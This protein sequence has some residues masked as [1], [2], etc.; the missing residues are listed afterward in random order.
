MRK[1]QCSD[2]GSNWKATY[3]PRRARAT[4]SGGG[5]PIARTRSEKAWAT[6][7]SQLW[8]MSSMGQGGPAQEAQ[9]GPCSGVVIEDDE[10]VEVATS[11]GGDEPG[12]G[13]RRAA[14]P[15]PTLLVAGGSARP[16]PREQ[17]VFVGVALGEEEEEDLLGGVD[18]KGVEVEGPEASGGGGRP[19]GGR[20]AAG[21]VPHVLGAAGGTE[22]LGAECSTAALWSPRD[23]SARRRMQRA[24]RWWRVLRHPPVVPVQPG[25]AGAPR[26]RAGASEPGLTM[27]GRAGRRG[28]RTAPRRPGGSAVPPPP[29]GGRRGA[30]P[31]RTK[32]GFE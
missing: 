13:S 27:E 5:A 20:T 16:E 17:V 10:D 9:E 18:G 3:R 22:E 7:M 19:G 29:S 30:M 4:G 1:A 15:A 25:E 28:R 6:S 26:R 11:G 21:P 31:R 8:M 23:D 2:R 14:R 24:R 12:G 32:S